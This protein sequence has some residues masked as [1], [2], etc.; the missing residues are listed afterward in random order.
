MYEESAQLRVFDHI[1]SQT[2]VGDRCSLLALRELVAR[3]GPYAYLEIGSHLGGTLQPFVVDERCRAIVSIDS[4]PASQPDNRLPEGEHYRYDG[5]ST[6]RML[7]LLSEIDGADTSKIRTIDAGTDAI[8]PSSIVEAPTL[9]LIDGEHTDVAALR[10]A[11]FCAAVAPRSIIAFHDR[12]VVARAISAFMRVAG[13]YGHPLPDNVFVVD[14]GGQRRMDFLQE[15]PWTWR[16]ANAAGIAGE[17]AVVSPFVRSV[18][19][20]LRTAC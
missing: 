3:D 8:A 6:D 2:S 7:S 16:A 5:N 4:R 1:E 13:G 9:C 19:R 11:L 18:S 17:G 14:F 10:D 15:R 12:R 20:R